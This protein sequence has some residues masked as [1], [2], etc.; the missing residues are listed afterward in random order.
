MV[1][2]IINHSV[3]LVFHAYAPYHYVAGVHQ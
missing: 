2:D 1:P 3:A